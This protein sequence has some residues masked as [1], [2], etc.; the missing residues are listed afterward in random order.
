M[1]NTP[2]WRDK[3]KIVISFLEVFMLHGC[4]MAWRMM[5]GKIIRFIGFEWARINEDVYLTCLIL[6][7]IKSHVHCFWFFC[8]TVELTMTNVVKLPV[9]IV[10]GGF[11]WKIYSSVVRSGIVVWPLCKNASSLASTADAM[12]WR[13]TPHLVWSGTLFIDF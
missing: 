1:L 12:T 7:P 9:S 3:S 13:S 8:L 5:F 10:V 11:W 2:L 6:D 4:V